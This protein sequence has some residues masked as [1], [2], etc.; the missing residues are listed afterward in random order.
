MEMEND[1][2]KFVAI[3]LA[4]GGG[5]EGAAFFHL[6]DKY[7]NAV[8]ADMLAECLKMAKFS[9]LQEWAE[10]AVLTETIRLANGEP[11][12]EPMR[13][14]IAGWCQRR[15]D[16]KRQP[17]SDVRKANVQWAFIEKTLN[18]PSCKR[19]AIVVELADKFELKRRQIF[20]F[21]K[22]IDPEKY[23][24]MGLS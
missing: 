9:R 13:A 22:G 8:A 11:V 18:D 2:R 6:M 7:P 1:D 15:L 16:G 4:L 5:C 10:A 3:M 12:G 21:I 14:A 19:E 20:N 24:A 23:R 17:R